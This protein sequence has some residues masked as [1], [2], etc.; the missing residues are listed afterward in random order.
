MDLFVF[1][2]NSIIYKQTFQNKKKL[3][4]GI[5]IDVNNNGQLLLQSGLQLLMVTFIHVENNKKNNK[6]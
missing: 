4:N 6:N 2:I 5:D 1:W 3:S